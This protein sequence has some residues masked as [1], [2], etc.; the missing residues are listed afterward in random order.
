MP[1]GAAAYSAIE[2]AAQPAE[3]GK[4]RLR[5]GDVVSVAVFQEPDLSRDKI[6]IDAAGDLNLP[7]IGEIRAAGLTASELA[8]SIEQRYGARY[9]RD[10]RVSVFMDEGFRQTISVEGHVAQPGV[11]PYETGQTL[12]TALAL[13]RSPT[14][15]AALDEIVIFRTV[16]GQ[17]Y[18]GR[19]DLRAIRGG[20]AADPEL[21]S[22]DVIV[23]GY[24]NLRGA[25]RDVLQAAPLLGIFRPL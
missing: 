10:P 6:A 17:R 14:Q 11:Y 13:A 23:V 2:T 15:V 4:Y 9:L 25:Y 22:G 24:S 20:R 19:F 5:S 3:P 1:A 7:L 8:R 18:G 21:R 12:L 16:D